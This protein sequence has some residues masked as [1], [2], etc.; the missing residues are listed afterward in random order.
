LH[1]AHPHIERLHH[2]LAAHRPRFAD[3]PP[4]VPRAAVALVV[5]P[6]LTDLELLLIK[7]AEV[8]GDPWSGHMALPGGR[9]S[10]DDADDVD[11]AVR[12]T[13]EEVGIDLDDGGLLLGRLDDVAPARGAPSIVIAPF[14]FSTAAGTQVQPNREV[15]RSFWV[16]LPLLASPGAATDYLHALENGAELRFPAIGYKDHVIWGLTYRIVRQFL[17]FA[18][19]L[20]GQGAVK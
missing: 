13:R 6:G 11:T 10:P 5:R 8:S 19:E 12:E 1:P 2:L 14:V 16:E 9:R 20:P 15:D 3:Q 4:E 7:R 18:R 17:E